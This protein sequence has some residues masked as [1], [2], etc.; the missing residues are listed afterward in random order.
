MSQ[1]VTVAKKDEI[2]PAGCKKVELG[3][4]KLAVFHVDGDFYVIDD[5]C[6]HAE[7][8]LSEGQL[9]GTIVRCPRHGAKFDITN[10]KA[11]SL[12]A[13]KPVR[14]YKV[15]LAGDEVQVELEID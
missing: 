2:A 14:S 13:F 8:S 11:L 15:Q 10:G 5:T 12:P 4:Y 1:F 3:N 7:A 9:E 6:S